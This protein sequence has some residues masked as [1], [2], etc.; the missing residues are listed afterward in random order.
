MKLSLDALDMIANLFCRDRLSQHKVQRTKK[1]NWQ[2]AGI[3]KTVISDTDHTLTAPFTRAVL[4]QG[5]IGFWMFQGNLSDFTPGKNSLIVDNCRFSVNPR[6]GFPENM[7]LSSFSIEGG[8]TTR[9]VVLGSSFSIE[10][11]FIL[12]SFRRYRTL[13]SLLDPENLFTLLKVTVT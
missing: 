11:V 3:R 10:V 8:K 2:F 7:A 13:F 5:P 12:T 6:L 9:P 4:E 1:W